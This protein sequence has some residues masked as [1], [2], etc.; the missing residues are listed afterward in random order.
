MVNFA[1]VRSLV[2]GAC[3]REGG[4]VEGVEVCVVGGVV[5]IASFDEGECVVVVVSLGFCYVACIAVCAAVC[6]RV[7]TIVYIATCT[8][9]CVAVCGRICTVVCIT[10]CAAVCAAVCG[11]VCTIICIATCTGAC[12]AVCGRIRTV[13]C[14]AICTAICT[15]TGI[16]ICTAT[17]AVICSA[18]CT[19]I[20]VS[21]GIAVRI[22]RAC[23]RSNPVELA[24][25]QYQPTNG[26][27]GLLDAIAGDW[28][29]E[30]VEVKFLQTK[31]INV[32][33]GFN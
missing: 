7:C 24:L 28:S 1:G 31:D 21:A 27:V 6:G 19:T 12:V 30:C 10:T 33:I 18:T 8:G 32:Y 3:L 23:L 11:R 5:F 22:A 13:V 26:I 20:Y 25:A 14:I 4:V 29:L 16:A 2:L 9:A 17:R 15:S